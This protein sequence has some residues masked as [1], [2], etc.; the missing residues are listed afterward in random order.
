MDVIPLDA[1]LVKGS[2][3]RITD[4]SEDGS[5]LISSDAGLLPD[6]AVSATKVKNVILAHVFS[7]DVV[8]KEDR[9]YARL[10]NAK[11]VRRKG[12]PLK[13]KTTRWQKQGNSCTL[14]PLTPIGENS[15]SVTNIRS[16]SRATFSRL[17]TGSLS[18]RSRASSRIAVIR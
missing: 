10:S 15:R 11:S 8:P 17:R 6:G 5:V 13:A 9:S 14:R 7:W 4:M 18:K 16:F 2:H 1:S 3:G 12:S